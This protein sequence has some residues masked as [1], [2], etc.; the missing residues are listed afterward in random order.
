MRRARTKR[1]PGRA[2]SQRSRKTLPALKFSDALRDR[3]IDLHPIATTIA[4]F[5]DRHVHTAR[6]SSSALL[7]D[8]N[9][10]LRAVAEIR[11]R[12]LRTLKARSG[13]SLKRLITAL[14][15]FENESARMGEFAGVI[16]PRPGM[17]ANHV[18]LWI[19]GILQGE[20]QSH[21]GGDLRLPWAKIDA[22]LQENCGE[23]TRD[24]GSLSK[25]VE[26]NR[27]GA[28][29]CSARDIGLSNDAEWPHLTPLRA[30]AQ[31]KSD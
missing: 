2:L 16:T 26:R 31:R 4:Q 24:R 21:Y 28:W 6:V 15:E 5:Y 3:V 9:D 22:C 8:A 11:E 18:H 20:A 12:E 1:Q 23:H 29:F 30:R 19:A 13:R 14:E 27:E 17:R 10:A 7:R 25:D